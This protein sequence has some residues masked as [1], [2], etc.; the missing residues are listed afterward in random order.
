MSAQMKNSISTRLSVE[1]ARVSNLIAQ[2]FQQNLELFI[3]RS[4]VITIIRVVKISS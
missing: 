3:I 4:G 1:F 2:F